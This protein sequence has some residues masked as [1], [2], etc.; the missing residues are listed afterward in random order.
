MSVSL[1][2]LF[3]T[4][5]GGPA[6]VCRYQSRGW[7]SKATSV[8]ALAR[9]QAVELPGGAGRRLGDAEVPQDAPRRR[10]EHDAALGPGGEVAER[11]VRLH[12]GR[13]MIVEA[14]VPRGGPTLI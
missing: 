4:Y 1:L 3:L 9:T 7:G 8:P 12:H 6:G 14:R 11:A 13:V 5:A 10:H 2:L